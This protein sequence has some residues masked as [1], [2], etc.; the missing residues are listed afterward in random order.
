MSENKYY[1]GID[2][3][4]TFCKTVIINS[5]QN[6]IVSKAIAMIQGNPKKAAETCL[7]ES[8]K[9]INVNQKELKK[10]AISTGQNGSKTEI[11]VKISEITCIG[12][13]AFF[14]NPQICIVVDVGSF[15]MKVLKLDDKGV[16][17]DYLMND[18]CAAGSGVLLELVAE[19]L[20]MEVDEISDKAF[21]SKNPIQIS[22]QCSIFAESEVISYK[23]EGADVADLLAGVCN[24]VAGRI[25]PLVR[26]IEKNPQNV[27]F[28]GGVALNSK[29]V[30][31]LEKRLNL[32]LLQLE[33][34]PQFIAA[35]GA[36]LLAKS[37]S[38]GN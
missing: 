3:G 25:Y 27:A 21:E 23:N 28:T 7:K 9:T 14:L 31:N 11:G 35:Y 8:L 26:K 38:G 15:S 30:E 20:E 34:E 19:G 22:S 17:K 37:K 12:E 36:A 16:I 4:A 5:N 24:S 10:E 13:A 33:I 6:S 2:A 32:E 29:I 1:L 18:K